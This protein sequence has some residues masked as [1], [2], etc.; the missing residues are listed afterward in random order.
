MFVHWEIVYW[1]Y[2]SRGLVSNYLVLCMSNRFIHWEQSNM[3]VEDLYVHC[4]TIY[5]RFVAHDDWL[6]D[7]AMLKEASISL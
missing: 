6:G 7:D 5:F 4:I 3:S 1:Q 2:I